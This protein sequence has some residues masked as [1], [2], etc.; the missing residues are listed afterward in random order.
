[1]TLVHACCL[2]FSFLNLETELDVCSTTLCIFTPSNV[3]ILNYVY[4]LSVNS[5]P[6]VKLPYK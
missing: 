2:Q 3:A 1:M 4:S 6:N 5:F